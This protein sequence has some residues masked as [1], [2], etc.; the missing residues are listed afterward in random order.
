MKHAREDYD[1]RIQDAEGLIPQ[2]EPVFL[3]RAQ[4]AI[5]VLTVRF[6]AETA[7]AMGVSPVIV[8]QVRQHIRRFEDWRLLNGVK[9]PDAPHNLT[10]RGAMPAPASPAVRARFPLEE[11]WCINAIRDVLEDPNLKL[12]AKL[13]IISGMANTKVELDDFRNRIPGV[14]DGVKVAPWTSW[15]PAMV[16]VIIDDKLIDAGVKLAEIE[17]TILKKDSFK[18]A[19]N[20]GLT[21]AEAWKEELE[22]LRREADPA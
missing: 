6:W 17:Y 14:V 20:S 11:W 19:F 4:D 13:R 7:A 2:D 21:P 8:E 16:K 10:Q 5:S 18:D 15:A 22:D 9:L 1:R 12:E 3:L